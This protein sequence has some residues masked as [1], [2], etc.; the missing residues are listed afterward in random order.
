MCVCEAVGGVID[1]EVDTEGSGR[2]EDVANLRF[3]IGVESNS[4]E[5]EQGLVML[6]NATSKLQKRRF[7]DD[8]AKIKFAQAHSHDDQRW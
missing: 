7:P 6:S 5:M 3:E 8:P 1:V 4:V 2:G